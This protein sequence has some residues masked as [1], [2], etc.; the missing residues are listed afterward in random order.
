[1]RVRLLPRHQQDAKHHWVSDAKLCTSMNSDMPRTKHVMFFFEVGCVNCVLLGFCQSR[2][3][4]GVCVTICRYKKGFDQCLG[5]SWLFLKNLWFQSFKNMRIFR[6][7]FHQKM[8]PAFGLV[9]ENKKFIFQF[10]KSNPTP[11][12]VWVT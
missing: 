4:V 12:P 10:W 1:M 9:L 5:G 7:Q 3:R 11:V 6:F 8:K 2:L